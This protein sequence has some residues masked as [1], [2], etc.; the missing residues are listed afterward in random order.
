MDPVRPLARSLVPLPDE[1]IAG[2]L[3]RLSH[4]LGF[5]SGHLLFRTG[6]NPRESSHTASPKHLLALEPGPLTTFSLTTKLSEHEADRLTLRPYLDRYP[7]LA[8]ALIRDDSARPRGIFPHWLLA[9]PTRCCPRCLA[10]DSSTSSVD[11]EAPG[12]S[13]GTCRSSSP[14]WNTRSSCTT[15]APAASSPSTAASRAAPAG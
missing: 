12:N 14:A 8:D 9:G 11:T 1:S 5:S 6:L 13:N 2:F 3:L 7:P 10:G 15:P 4:R